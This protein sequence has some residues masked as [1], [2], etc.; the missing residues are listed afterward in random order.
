MEQHI[1]EALIAAIDGKNRS[2]KSLAIQN[3]AAF[4]STR[5]LPVLAISS[6]D[7]YRAVT[8]YMFRAQLAV[9]AEKVASVDVD[10]LLRLCRNYGIGIRNGQ[11]SVGGGPL[12]DKEL[13]APFVDTL[14]PY[15]AQLPGVRDYVN[16]LVRAAAYAFKGLVLVDGRDVATAIFPT[17]QLKIYADVSDEE[18]ARRGGVTVEEV[19]ER[20]R[21]DSSRSLSP[22]TVAEG[23]VVV[24]TTGVSPEGV[25][26]RIIKLIGKAFPEYKIE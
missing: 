2:G 20:N 5:G 9:A 11:V 22:M 23:A 4:Y 1:S 14:V 12:T 13:K 3:V 26:D 25:R 6:G 17:A 10:R 21:I 24:D 16:E 18:A 7:V 19:R 8:Y 15:V